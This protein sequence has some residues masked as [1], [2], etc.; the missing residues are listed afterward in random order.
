MEASQMWQILKCGGA[1]RYRLA[2][3]TSNL[4]GT[5]SG[6]CARG[7]AAD[8]AHV[9]VPMWL[10]VRRRPSPAL[11]RR[12]HGACSPLAEGMAATS[13]GTYNACS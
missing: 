6:P 13:P 12:R 1:G 9:A 2:Q 7:R 11:D 8:G 5:E 10:R 4:Q 3:T